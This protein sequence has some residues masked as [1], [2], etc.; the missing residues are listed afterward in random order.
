M[1]NSD[2]ALH[3]RR[4]GIAGESRLHST[5]VLVKDATG[6]METFVP[7]PSRITDL[8]IGQGL[9]VAMKRRILGAVARRG[10]VGKDYRLNHS[11]D[12]VCPAV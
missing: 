2:L 6:G 11:T 3:W 4:V 12:G 5:H 1:R 8:L 7:N 9:A 10:S